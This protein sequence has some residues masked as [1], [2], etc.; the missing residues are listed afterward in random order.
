MKEKR[1]KFLESR[2]VLVGQEWENAE[3]EL[4][5]EKKSQ[6]RELQRIPHTWSISFAQ[7]RN[8]NPLKLLLNPLLSYSIEPLKVNLVT[9]WGWGINT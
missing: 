5:E 8:L 9:N 1:Q 7:Q 2:E 3:A 4:D 6:V